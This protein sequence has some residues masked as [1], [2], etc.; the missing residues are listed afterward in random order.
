MDRW[1]TFR[2]WVLSIYSDVTQRSS[3]VGIVGCRSKGDQ[4]QGWRGSECGYRLVLDQRERVREGRGERGEQ[5]AESREQRAESRRKGANDAQ[6]SKTEHDAGT[7]LARIAR[8]Q[9]RE[10][11]SMKGPVTNCLGER[12]TVRSSAARSKGWKLGWHGVKSE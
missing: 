9:G 12:F 10:K 6:Y 7:G 1:R 8:Y 4:V 2:D 5:R 11:I 3:D